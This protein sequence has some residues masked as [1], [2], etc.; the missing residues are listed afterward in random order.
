MALEI[1]TENLDG[2]LL[3]A[4]KEQV[5]DIPCESEELSSACSLF[6]IHATACVHELPP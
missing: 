1:F 5:Y 3:T 2:Y 4:C 6:E